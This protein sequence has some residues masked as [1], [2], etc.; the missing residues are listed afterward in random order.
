MTGENV[1]AP[2]SGW[3]EGT[4]FL[5]KGLFAGNLLA[6]DS[7]G[8]RVVRIAPP[9]IAGLYGPPQTFIGGLSSPIGIAVNS[10]GSVF[11]TEF[12][13]RIRRFNSVGQMGITFVDGLGLPFF[14]EFDGA[15][16]LYVV[17][18]VTGSVLKYAPDGTQVEDMNWPSFLETV[19][20]PNNEG[21]I[22]I[23]KKY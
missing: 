3:G 21:P 17:E 1:V 8:G 11:V 23:G 7:T 14:I 16:N 6:V 15:D 2:F 12:G 9:A 4:V 19:T 10:E 20:D 22:G 13:G 18:N 5:T